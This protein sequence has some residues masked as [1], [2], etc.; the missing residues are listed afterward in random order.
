M[1]QNIIKDVKASS[2]TEKVVE[3]GS[4]VDDDASDG[5]GGSDGG[6]WLNEDNLDEV[7]E[8]VGEVAVPE[9]NMKVRFLVTNACVK[10]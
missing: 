2:G 3:C 10:P 1:L 4:D 6:T 5:S 9:K 7:L 8:H